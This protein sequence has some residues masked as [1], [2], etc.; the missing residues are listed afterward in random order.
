MT[1]PTTSKPHHLRQA[2]HGGHIVP[3][4]PDGTA[5]HVAALA[6]TVLTRADAGVTEQDVEESTP[7]GY[8]L[9]DLQRRFPDAHLPQDDPAATVR[10]L[11]ALGAAMG[12]AES[13]DPALDSSVPAVYTYW[14]QFVDHDLTLSTDSDIGPSDVTLEDLRPLPPAE[15][16]QVLTNLRQPALNLDSVYGGG[17]QDEEW[18]HLY[19]DDRELKVGVLAEQPR[20]GGSPIPGD[21]VPPADDAARDLP[22]D[23]T[24]ALVGDPRNDENLIVAQLHLA[25]LRFHNAAVRAL[26][27]AGDPYRRSGGGDE[28]EDDFDRARRL[29]RWHYQWLTVHDYLRT[30]T[31]PGIVDDVLQDGGRRLRRDGTVFMPLEF[32]VAA[33][34]FGHSMIRAAYDYN[35]NFGAEAK[36]I[37][38]A[39]LDLLFRFTGQSPQPFGGDTD[40]LPFNWVIEWD[41]FVSKDDPDPRHSARRMDTQVVPPLQQMPNQGNGPGLDPRAVKILKSLPTRNLLR[42]Y[43]LAMPTGQHAAEALGVPA[44]T[45]EELRQGNP[46]AVDEAL[47]AGG[48]LERTPLWYYLLKEAE[49]RAGGQTLGELGSRIVSE[50]IIGQL[51]EDE[52]SYLS[53]EPDWSPERGVR[54]PSAGAD[55]STLVDS[56]PAF[57]RF[58]GVLA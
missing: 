26:P 18:R 35:R 45:A 8:L 16:L 4:Q 53:R 5:D 25:F 31:L 6:Q 30:V 47:A 55:G 29:T 40:T 46:P 2:V 10:A 42:G 57:L 20:P 11:E 17:P 9:D 34:R 52:L 1:A 49:I 3:E 12:E 27:A 33:F 24:K 28:D 44:L 54:L 7:F 50:T 14:G 15:V 22:R 23:G 36:V 32:S 58:A 38:A 19:A 48:F 43:L 39:P 56:I 13:P 21:H 37:P 51:R 41:R